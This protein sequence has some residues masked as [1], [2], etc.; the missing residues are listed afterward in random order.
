MQHPSAAWLGWVGMS[1]GCSYWCQRTK[2]VVALPHSL[3]GAGESESLPLPGQ[4]QC[5]YTDKALFCC[6]AKAVGVHRKHQDIFPAALLK[7]A[8]MPYTFHSPTAFL[9]TTGIHRPQR[10]HP[11]IT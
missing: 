4:S 3:A 2:G 1:G 9:R 6:T 5:M 11:L 10:G 8:S 7:P